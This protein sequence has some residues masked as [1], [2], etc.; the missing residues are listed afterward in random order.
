VRSSQLCEF[1]YDRTH[2]VWLA[3]SSDWLVAKPLQIL[4]LIVIAMVARFLIHRT[5][6]RVIRHTIEAGTGNLLGSLRDRLSPTLRDRIS[7][8]LRAAAV[9]PSERRRQRTEALG[10]VLRSISSATVLTITLMMILAE[11]GVD[12]GPI[13]ASAGI[14]GIAVGLGAQ[15]L[16][17]DFLAGMFILVEDQFGVG[18]AVDLG[19]MTAVVT[20][21]VEAVGLRITTVR[22]DRGALWYIRNGEIIRV[23]NKSQGWSLVVVDVQVGFALVERATEV[24]T[25]A[26][27]ELAADPAWADDLTEP[28]EL[29]GIEEIVPDAT[30]LRSTAKTSPEARFRL[31]REMRL[32]ITRAL[33]A[34]GL[35]TQADTVATSVAP[36]DEPARKAD[37]APIDEPARKAD[38]APTEKPARKADITRPRPPQPGP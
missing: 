10:S 26:I 35:D 24:L 4:L 31:A 7:P 13:L 34:A 12:L 19:Q 29:L 33:A 15:N 11:L 3:E 2:R 38:A 6:N 22:D 23:G 32:R 21:T 36:I 1:V 17:R 30:I 28:P 14:V 18:D 16:V 20:G 25:A 8:A 5:I 9:L 37:A 27:A